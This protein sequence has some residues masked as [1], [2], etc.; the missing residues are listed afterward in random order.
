V[1]PVLPPAGGQREPGQVDQRHEHRGDQAER[2]MEPGSERAH[3]PPVLPLVDGIDPG[4]PEARQDVQRFT[5]G[6]ADGQP[7][8][9]DDQAA[10]RLEPQEHPECE[11]QR[12][13]QAAGAAV[14]ARDA[15]VRAQTR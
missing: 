7:G 11:E 13:A 2:V 10:H 12:G 14:R 8:D 1:D 6:G 5:R 9:E 4:E 3:T 15:G